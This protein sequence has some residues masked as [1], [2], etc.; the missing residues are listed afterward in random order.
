MENKNLL[1]LQGLLYQMQKVASSFKEAD[2][3]DPIEPN[4]TFINKNVDETYTV[5][6]LIPGPTGNNNLVKVTTDNGEERQYEI[7]SF[8]ESVEKVDPIPGAEGV[9]I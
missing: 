8:E 9:I 7:Q 4:Q 2:M 3:V 5:D 1:I 6:E